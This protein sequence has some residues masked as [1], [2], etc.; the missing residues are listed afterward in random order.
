M[1]LLLVFSTLSCSDLFLL[2]T[3]LQ[4]KPDA[5]NALGLWWSFPFRVMTISSGDPLYT[6]PRTQPAQSMEF[7]I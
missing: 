7:D 4:D 1:D 6:T 2:S 5:I 3:H